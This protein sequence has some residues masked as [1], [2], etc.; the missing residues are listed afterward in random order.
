MV[1]TA[2]DLAHKLTER[3][4]TLCSG[5]SVEGHPEY[6][7]LNDATHEDGAAEYS[8]VRRIGSAEYVQIESITFSWCSWQEALRYVQQALAGD[9]DGNDF[10]RPVTVHLEAPEQ[11]GRCHHCA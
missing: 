10:A 11:H 7:F 1:A 9:M 2:E 3:T 5:F 4:W 6:L 8:I